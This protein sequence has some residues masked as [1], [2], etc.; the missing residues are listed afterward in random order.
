M[1][2]WRTRPPR[3]RA[4]SIR[5]SWQRRRAAHQPGAGTA[6][7][8]RRMPTPRSSS[9][10]PWGGGDRRAALPIPDLQCG[11]QKRGEEGRAVLGASVDEALDVRARADVIERVSG[12]EEEREDGGLCHVPTAARRWA[13]ARARSR[14]GESR[15]RGSE[16]RRGGC[17]CRANHG[18]AAAAV[19][20]REEIGFWE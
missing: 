13:E 17:R 10:R 8:R 4:A 1:Q 14:G 7:Q 6:Q 19:G 15:S 18:V 9:P 11:G 20:K 16:S 5:V 2:R 12:A 3:W